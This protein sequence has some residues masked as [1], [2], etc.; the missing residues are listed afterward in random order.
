MFKIPIV[1]VDN[2][3]EHL[4]KLNAAFAL[5]AM[6]CLPIRFISDPDNKSGV[7]HVSADSR[8]ARIVA[9]DINLQD[10]GGTL[11]AKGLY[12]AI[13]G[14]LKKLAPSGPYFLIFW[15]RHKNLP[16]EIMRLLAT[17]SGDDVVAPIGWHFL[18]KSDFLDGNG[19]SLKER[20]LE[21]IGDA[22]IFRLLLEW[23][24]RTGNAA[25]ETLSGLYM[26][27]ARAS[28]SGWDYAQTAQNLTTLMTHI[29][30]EALGH[31]NAKDSASHA[32]ESGLLPMVEDRL[33]ILSGEDREDLNDQWNTCLDKLGE[34]KK[35]GSLSKADAAN[36]NT[37]YHIE[38]LPEG[39]SKCKRG[40][41]V[42]LPDSFR[43]DNSAFG[44][45]FGSENTVQKVMTEEFVFAAK[46]AVKS[47]VINETKLGWLEIGAE[48]DHAQRKNRLHR[49]VL[50]AL[51]PEKYSGSLYSDKRDIKDRAHEG[52]YRFPVVSYR[53]ESYIILISFRYQI[54]A[55][56]GSEALGD[57][58]FRVKEQI[59]TDIAFRWSKHSIRPGITS[60]TP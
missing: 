47:D 5:S 15:S 17:R 51:V 34:P 4:D 40:V 11:D 59:L 53:N 39:Y 29:A 58:M 38:E 9:L 57:P 55:H 8:H 60:F 36:L 27:A 49:Y 23:E 43:N 19:E 30:H 1:I 24:Q 10:A 25:S 44:T 50:G 31:K 22:C 35:L 20:L 3:Q 56:T 2:E 6:P 41:F 48:C 7:D 28:G 18:D 33:A 21:A 46:T 14:V 54:G 12:P 37:F 13:E 16:E 52:V 26:L 45:L 32:V 42:S